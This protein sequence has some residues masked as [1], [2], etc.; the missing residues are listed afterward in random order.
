[1]YTLR[2]CLA[3]PEN[4]NW[5]GK[6]DTTRGPYYHHDRGSKVLGVAHLDTVI[7][8]KPHKE[9]S[10]IFSPML[11]DRLGVWCLLNALP[12]MGIDLDILLTTGEESCA[13]TADAFYGEYNWVV[14]F[15]RA[16][17]DVVFYDYENCEDWLWAWDGWKWGK[18]SYSDICALN[19]GV[20]GANVGIG[21]YNQHTRYCHA[22][23]K[24]TRTQLEKFESFYWE[25]RDTKFPFVP[26]PSFA[27]PYG[28]RGP[29]TYDPFP[30][31]DSD[32]DRGLLLDRFDRF[33]RL[34]L[35]DRDQADRDQADCDR[36]LPSYDYDPWTGSTK[37]G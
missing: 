34:A 29:P 3:L 35:A 23:L 26:A 8:A 17:M 12:R 31:S 21:Y 30:D 24:D 33:D 20:C 19:I 1:M 2:Q 32:S 6:V 16:G 18:G 10:H 9:G 5:G 13:S 14:E 7:Q 25:H 22:N 27:D 28:F 15:D 37:W 4:H 36:D 11:D